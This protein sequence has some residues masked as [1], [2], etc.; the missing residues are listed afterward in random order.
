[1]ELDGTLD[2]EGGRGRG[3]ERRG[4]AKRAEGVGCTETSAA[5]H[6]EEEDKG[7]IRSRTAHDVECVYGSV[8]EKVE[9]VV[10]KVV[11]AV[12]KS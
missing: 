7:S 1:M 3:E 10:D 5:R 6:V 12:K 9:V 8:V 2:R 4:E 11:V